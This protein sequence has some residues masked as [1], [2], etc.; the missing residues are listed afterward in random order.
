MIN[1][2]VNKWNEALN[3]GCQLMK[4]YDDY[5]S[6]SFDDVYGGEDTISII[7]QFAERIYANAPNEV[8]DLLEILRNVIDNKPLA[9]EI[10][11]LVDR[12]NYFIY[13]YY[14]RESEV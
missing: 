14:R 5:D 11:E 9:F 1:F 10:I 12:I 3:L 13:D 7:K 6:Y 2:D 4:F 8:R